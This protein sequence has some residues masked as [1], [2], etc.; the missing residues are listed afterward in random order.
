MYYY[1]SSELAEQ[2]GVSRRTVTNWIKQASTGKLNLRLIEIEGIYYIVKSEKNQERLANIVQERRKYLNKRSHK[3][4]QPT[5]SFYD[6]FT[7]GQIADIVRSLLSDRE[8]P[9]QYTYFGEGA[10]LWD[11]FR[12]D[13][14]VIDA[15][16]LLEASASYLDWL[17]S[18]Y[19]SVNIVD[20]GVGNGQAVKPLVAMLR[21]SGKLKKY[22]GIDLSPDMIRIAEGN[23]RSWFDDLEID[24]H[25]RD[26]SRETFGDL[27][28]Q[29]HDPVTQ[30]SST[31]NLVLMLGGQM[32]NFKD[33]VSVLGLVNRSMGADD[34]LVTNFKLGIP[35]VKKQLAFI[36]GYQ[37]RAELIMNML[38]IDRS[39]YE[40]EIG[41]D[42]EEKIR[43]SRIKF[44]R[45]VTVEVGTSQ[46]SWFVTFNK[47]ERILTFRAQYNEPGSILEDI[48]VRAG[49]NPLMTAQRVD[50]QGMLLIADTRQ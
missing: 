48:F 39:L 33:P 45:A 17:L 9:L 50:H 27:I 6:T 19:D 26:F 30:Q 34:I 12:R 42:E 4:L 31:I 14:G 44:N 23:L 29:M 38:G 7:E 28:T 21:E 35:E 47:D 3:H 10:R 8:L 41:Y 22:T 20:V 5:Q 24:M 49:F 32:S 2:Y 37:T 36:S 18:E 11:K 15:E 16:K 25:L 43:Y 1:K 40:A 46:G 13:S